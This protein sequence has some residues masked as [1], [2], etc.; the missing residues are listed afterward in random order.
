MTQMGH[1]SKLRVN[2]SSMLSG[3]TSAR[4]SALGKALKRILN[5]DQDRLLPGYAELIQLVKSSTVAAQEDRKEEER[6]YYEAQIAR[7]SKDRR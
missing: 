3:D 6:A 4:L 1:A 2:S 5:P 7:F